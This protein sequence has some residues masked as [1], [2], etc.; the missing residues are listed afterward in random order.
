M[1]KNIQ[2]NKMMVCISAIA[3]LAIMA[4][5]FVYSSHGG[6]K[7]NNV[8]GS[9]T[10]KVIHAFKAEYDEL[11]AQ[12]QKVV[13]D[14]WNYYIRRVA[15]FCEYAAL[16]FWMYVH[17]VAARG[18]KALKD[19]AKAARKAGRDCSA[20]AARGSKA[21]KNY[22]WLLGVLVAF[23]YACSD[24]LHQYFIPGRSGVFKDAL[25]DSVG[26]LFGAWIAVMVV[27]AIRKRILSKGES[28]D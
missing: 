20:A 18:S 10:V 4:L 6:T 11:P 14:N 26:A 8:S 9:V 5:I 15:H 1:R 13:F 22:D 12:E 28:H 25:W 16:S 19:E 2:Y 17:I 3:V 24:E 23:L 7:S 27:K 21:R